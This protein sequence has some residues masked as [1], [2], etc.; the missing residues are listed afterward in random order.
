MGT[1]TLHQ[2]FKTWNP[3]CLVLGV[4]KVIPFSFGDFA[5]MAS[6]I[7]YLNSC[8]MVLVSGEFCLTVPINGIFSI[9]PETLTR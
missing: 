1:E 3:F 2:E 8:V 4:T 7:P 9:L 6:S 5:L